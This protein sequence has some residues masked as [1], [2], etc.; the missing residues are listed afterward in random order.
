MANRFTTPGSR[1]IRTNVKTAKKRKASSTRWLDRQL[2]DPYVQQAKRDG[3]RSRAA[4]KLSEIDDKLKILKPGKHIVDLGAAP[5]GWMQIAAARTKAD[6]GSG[7]VIVGIDLLPIDPPI[8][9]THFFQ[10]DFMDET[11]PA[12]L[13]AMMKGQ[14]P[15][16]VLSDMAPNTSGHVSTDHLRIMGLCEAAFLFAVEVLKPGGSFVAK[17]WQGGAESSLLTEMKKRFTSV[18]HIKP[19]ASRADS[20]EMFVVALGFKG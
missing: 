4:Y 16:I 18:K 2:N 17:T 19:K 15:D 8:A 1:G 12:T 5:G 20:A 11:A 14:Q 6:A 9:G 3:F 10:G 13:R 7:S